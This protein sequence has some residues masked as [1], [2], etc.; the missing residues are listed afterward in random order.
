MG[1]EQ[2]KSPFQI[3]ER[4]INVIRLGIELALQTINIET[5]DWGWK[6]NFNISFNRNR[7]E[8]LSYGE[9]VIYSTNNVFALARV[10]E[11]VGVFY[12]WRAL[13]VYENDAANVWTD[14]ETGQTRKVLEGS[15]YGDAFGGK[16]MI[17]PFRHDMSG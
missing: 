17:W 3:S 9:D 5:A 14:P 1:K 10:N 13:G 6:T 2:T 8:S 16:D 15:M 12:G 11:P 4:A 7:I